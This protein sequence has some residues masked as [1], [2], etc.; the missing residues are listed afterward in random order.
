MSEPTTHDLYA[1]RYIQP[2]VAPEDTPR[3]LAPASPL[4]AL[5]AALTVA[6]DPPPPDDAITAN[7]AGRH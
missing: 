3:V 4:A 2:Y 1:E 5:Q 6:A 7:L